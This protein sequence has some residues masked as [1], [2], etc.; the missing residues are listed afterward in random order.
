RKGRKGVTS[1]KWN[2]RLA[3]AL[4]LFASSHPFL[5]AFARTLLVGF[6]LATFVSLHKS[7]PQSFRLFW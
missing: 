2:D 3:T 1:A 5:N 7:P 4:F 6:E